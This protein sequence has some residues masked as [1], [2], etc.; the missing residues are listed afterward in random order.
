MRISFSSSSTLLGVTFHRYH[1]HYRHQLF[2]MRN[3]G[4]HHKNSLSSTS[5][6]SSCRRHH[7]HH[8]AIIIVVVIFLVVVINTSISLVPLLSS[9]IFWTLFPL[10]SSLSSDCHL[11]YHKLL[12]TIVSSQTLADRMYGVMA[13][14]IPIF[15]ACSTFGAANG[16]AF[17]GGR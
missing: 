2:M 10:P 5:L 1:H 16:S 7:H 15:V 4:W 13:W 11:L 9:S 8:R 3:E 12:T 17:S 6:S 14:T